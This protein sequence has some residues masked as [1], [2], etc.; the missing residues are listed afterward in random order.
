[1]AVRDYQKKQLYNQKQT[2][3]EDYM[4]RRREDTRF[5]IEAPKE[6]KPAETQVC[7][8]FYFKKFVW[9]KWF[10]CTAIVISF[11]SVGM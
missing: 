8:I 10:F 2:K 7:P 1:M 3:Y 4:K 9:P 11:E 5:S 6:P